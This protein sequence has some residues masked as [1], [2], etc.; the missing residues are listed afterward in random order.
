MS[1]AIVLN[2]LHTTHDESRHV[3][4]AARMQAV[5]VALEQSGLL[6]DLVNLTAR[7]AS[8]A[9]IR[10]VHH[11]RLLETLR[12]SAAQE[13][14]WIDHDTYTTRFSH[15]AA[16]MASG[17]LLEAVH[18][19]AEQQVTNAFALIR[20]PGHHATANRSMGFCLLN[21][22]A[23]AATYAIQTLGYARVAIVDYD[24]H[25]GNGTQD[26]FYEDPHVLFIS[27]HG[28]PLYPGTGMEQEIGTGQ[29]LGTT[30]NLPVPYGAGDTGFAQLYEQII[31]PALTRFEP[32]LI[33]VSAGFDGHWNDPLGPLALSVS[34]YAQL[35]QRLIDLA[36]QICHGRIVLSLEGGYNEEALGACVVAA[37]Q[38]LLGRTP[39]PDLLGS[40]GTPEPDL[41]ALIER[42]QRQ[43]P[44]F[45]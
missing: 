6:P 14:L 27:T 18:A 35:T 37:T 36:Q 1:T 41:S 7:H 9:E 30:L 24:V 16:T 4:R 19:V 29:G 3:E 2:P 12:L 38:V 45:R 5:S 40:A 10:A 44:L 31:L 22:I 25:H 23:I 15:A 26:I 21:H 8:E 13:R 33:L 43:H 11:P 34:G 28:N 20:P 39:G 42:T 17:A 32:E